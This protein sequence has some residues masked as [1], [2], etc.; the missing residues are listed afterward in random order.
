M[1]LLTDQDVY[2][3]TVRFLRDLD[4]DTATVKETGLSRSGDLEILAAAGKQ[5]RIL[6]TRDRDFGSLVFL[7]RAGSGVLYLRLTPAT[8]GAVHAELRR[9][10]SLYTEQQLRNAFVVVETGRHRFR[11]LR[12]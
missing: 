9:V 2:A 10:L 5:G 8:T 6:V 7:R 4:H 12:R 11:I 1:R 3:S